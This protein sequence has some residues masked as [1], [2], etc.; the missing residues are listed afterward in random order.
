MISQ[1]EDD[2]DM[3]HSVRDF[4]NAYM[5]DADIAN[6]K[7]ASEKPEADPLRREVFRVIEETKGCFERLERYKSLQRQFEELGLNLK[8]KEEE[9]QV[10]L[11]RYET[12]SFDFMGLMRNY[13]GNVDYSMFQEYNE[14]KMPQIGK[15]DIGIEGPRNDGVFIPRHENQ[16]EEIS[17]EEYPKGGSFVFMDLPVPRMK[18]YYMAGDGLGANDDQMELKMAEKKVQNHHLMSGKLLSESED[19]FPPTLKPPKGKTTFESQ[20]AVP[21]TSKLNK[22]QNIGNNDSKKQ[23][24]NNPV[25][26]NDSIE[27][28]FES[29]QIKTP[30]RASVPPESREKKETIHSQNVKIQKVENEL[31][32]P[33]TQLTQSVVQNLPQKT[34]HKEKSPQISRQ[35]VDSFDF[36]SE[37]KP[38]DEPKP[39]VKVSLRESYNFSE[40]GKKNS[41]SLEN[42]SKAQIENQAKN[43]NS[44]AVDDDSFLFESGGN[45]VPPKKPS[46]NNDSFYDL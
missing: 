2:I 14:D 36:I 8:K 32:Q 45:E 39:I 17:L 22:K 37:T 29:P 21:S 34:P 42:N 40:A 16:R 19:Q 12:L 6:I 44:D 46:S 1:I 7:A 31:K 35:K 25:V 20:I 3:M 24:N 23:S 15:K 26:N 27:Y 10:L 38:N 43:K 30:F 9:Y 5:T 18:K 28:E 11:K 13:G 41:P 33:V 4:Y